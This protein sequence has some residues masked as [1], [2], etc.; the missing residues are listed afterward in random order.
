[1]R[2]GKV[3]NLFA[4]HRSTIITLYNGAF[5][6]SAAVFFI[7]KVHLGMDASCRC[8]DRSHV[9][10][11]YF[12]QIIQFCFCFLDPVRTGNL[13]PHVLPGDVLLQHRPPT[14]DL[15]SDAPVTHPLPSPT[16]LQL[17]VSR[18]D[19]WGRRCLLTPHTLSSLCTGSSVKRP[20]R[21]TWSSLRGWPCRRC[22]ALTGR[23]T[24]PRTPR[25]VH[26]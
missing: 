22:E 10:R 2:V 21:M 12:V 14:E 8:A 25:T 1:M 23:T 18:G 15:V 11:P 3:G 9:S 6:S 13:S 7:I 17:R 16:A 19:L 5:D 20:T 4:A 26:L 24:R